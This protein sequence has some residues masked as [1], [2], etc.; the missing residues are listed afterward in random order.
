MF[1]NQNARSFSN[2][3]NSKLYP[4]KHR[5]GKTKAETQISSR[6]SNQSETRSKRPESC[7]TSKK[8]ETFASKPTKSQQRQRQQLIFT[9]QINERVKKE[10]D[11]SKNTSLSNLH[12][13]TTVDSVNSLRGQSRADHFS[14]QSNN[15]SQVDELVRPG[16][17]LKGKQFKRQVKPT[18]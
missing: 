9:N 12:E 17:R 13:N 10:Q 5:D 18:L 11:V 7:E 2:L 15:L 6:F 14:T 3:H 16:R 1:I 8:I 4:I